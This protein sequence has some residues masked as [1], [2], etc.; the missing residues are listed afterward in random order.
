M[1]KIMF[2]CHGNICRSTMAEFV[3]KDIVNKNNCSDEFVISSSATSTEEIGNDTHWGTKQILD[4]IGIPYTKRQAIQLK[5]SDYEKYDFII[6]MD[7]ANM[8]NINRII[9]YDK[10]NKIHKL[11]NF[12]NMDRDVADPWY[13]RDFRTTYNDVLLGCTRLFEYIKGK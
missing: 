7:S 13:T 2:V 9:G 8:R 12:A 5:K 3:M 10:D 1:I 4:E 11:L 6:G